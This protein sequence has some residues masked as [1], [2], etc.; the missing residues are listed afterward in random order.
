MVLH[1]VQALNGLN[2]VGGASRLMDMLIKMPGPRNPAH[3]VHLAATLAD[4]GRWDE[5][6]RELDSILAELPGNPAAVELDRR[7]KREG[8]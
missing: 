3:R 5:G 4:L 6:R 8:R 2:Q 1:M 7:F